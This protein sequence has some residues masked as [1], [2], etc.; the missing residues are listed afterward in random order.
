MLSATISTLHA[1]DIPRLI[2]EGVVKGG[3]IPKLKSCMSALKG[4]VKKVHII[5]GRV[6]HSILLEVFTD[7]GIGT[8]IVP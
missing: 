4:G 5:D 6:P 3:M 1:R 7:E 8:Q 2:S